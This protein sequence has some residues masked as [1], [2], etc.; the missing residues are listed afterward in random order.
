MYLLQQASSGLISDLSR[1]LPAILNDLESS[2]PQ[3]VTRVHMG[4]GVAWAVLSE[5]VLEMQRLSTLQGYI[6]DRWVGCW[7][8]QWVGRLQGVGG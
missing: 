6:R 7:G 5:Q 2:R 4:T 1:T 8:L 3:C